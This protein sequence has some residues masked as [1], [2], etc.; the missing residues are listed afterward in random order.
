QVLD[1]IPLFRDDRDLALGLVVADEL[2]AAVD[3]GD[4]GHV[5]RHPRLEQLGNTRQTAGDVACLGGFARSTRE[6]VARLHLLAVIDRE[7]RARSEHV[8]RR[9]G[10][11]ALL[12]G[13]FAEQGQARTQVL[14]LRTTGGTILGDHALRD[15]GGLVDAFLHRLAFDQVLET[16]RARLLGDDR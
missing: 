10:F 6:N 12:A 1:R 5:L 8:T 14:L 11:L 9:L 4:R 2:D 15:A 7:S 16:D 3:L 13:F